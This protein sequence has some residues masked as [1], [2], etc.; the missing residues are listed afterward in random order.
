M[1]NKSANKQP[2]SN[3]LYARSLIEASLDPLVTISADGK[4]AD[5]NRATEEVTGVPRRKLIGSDFSD[6]FAEPEK[7][8][9]GYLPF[10]RDRGRPERG[11]AACSKSAGLR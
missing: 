6:Y 11:Q 5:V 4:I 8:R 7:A 3:S 1:G 2:C 9:E 10:P